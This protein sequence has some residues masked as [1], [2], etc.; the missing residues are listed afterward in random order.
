MLNKQQLYSAFDKTQQLKSDKK[1]DDNGGHELDSS[2]P[3]FTFQH[4]DDKNVGLSLSVVKEGSQLYNE[5]SVV[6]FDTLSTQVASIL[7]V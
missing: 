2:N 3:E 1:A 5:K 4:G 7:N 6:Q